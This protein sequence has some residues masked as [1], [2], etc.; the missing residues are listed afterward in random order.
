MDG[1]A[2]SSILTV[3]SG[4]HTIAAPVHLANDAFIDVEGAGN[5][6]TIS[7][8]L[9]TASGISLEKQGAGK[10]IL[11]AISVE[12]LLVGNGTLLISANGGDSGVTRVESLNIVEGGVGIGEG[13]RLDLSDNDL[14]VTYG[15]TPNPFDK[16]HRYMIEG[17]RDSVDP[18]AVGIVSSTSQ[19]NSGNAI[20]KLFDNFLAGVTEYAGVTVGANVVIGK[21]TYFGDLNLDGQVTADD[22]SFIDS[23]L[24]TTPPPGIACL[25]GDAN[26]DGTVN[27]DDYSAIDSNLGLGV[28]NPLAPASMPVPEPGTMGLGAIVA[29]AFLRPRRRRSD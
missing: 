12:A 17:Y 4:S 6:L 19:G 28:G 23:N 13:A 20:L 15:S 18:T 2:G 21:Y 24:N 3:Q 29:A 9:T 26:M 27:G 14:V 7:G 5:T 25:S 1:G 8:S 10:L 11:P 22:Y 16:L